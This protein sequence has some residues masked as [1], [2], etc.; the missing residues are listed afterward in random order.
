MSC[1]CNSETRFTYETLDLLTLSNRDFSL[2]NAAAI[3]GG[4]QALEKVHKDSSALKRELLATQE[5]NQFLE[6][7][8]SKLRGNTPRGWFAGESR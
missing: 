6:M 2:A 4:I 1:N 8:V 5:D 7:I 3:L